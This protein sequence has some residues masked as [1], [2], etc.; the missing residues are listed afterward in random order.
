MRMTYSLP[1]PSNGGE[2]QKRQGEAEPVIMPCRSRAEL[3]GFDRLPRDRSEWIGA[4]PDVAR[5]RLVRA[6][7]DGRRS[8]GDRSRPS[9]IITMSGAGPCQ[10][11]GDSHGPGDSDQQWRAQHHTIAAVTESV[12]KSAPV[13]AGARGHA[14]A[15]RLRHRTRGQLAGSSGRSAPPYLRHTPLLI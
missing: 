7:V 3:A 6:P 12:W 13:H 9:D 5:D 11:A 10:V 15:A 14:C 2:D 1:Q 8:H 4:S